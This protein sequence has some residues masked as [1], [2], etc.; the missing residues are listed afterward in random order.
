MM[1]NRESFV[2]LTL[3]SM[4]KHDVARLTEDEYNTAVRA[5]IRKYHMADRTGALDLHG[6]DLGYVGELIVETIQQNRITQHTLEIARN[7]R[8]LY[9]NKNMERNETA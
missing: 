2:A 1:R 5:V 3:R 8:E 4:V 9:Q 7:D 6:Q